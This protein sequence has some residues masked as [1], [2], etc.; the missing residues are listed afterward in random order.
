MLIYKQ[1]VNRLIHRTIFY[2]LMMVLMTNLN[3]IDLYVDLQY[4]M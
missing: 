2:H 1:L 4:L 3:R